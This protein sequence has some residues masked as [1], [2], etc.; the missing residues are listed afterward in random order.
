[1]QERKYVDSLIG[2]EYKQWVQGDKILISTPTGSGKTTFVISKLLKYAVEQRKH[3]AY[4]CNRRVLYEQIVV[5]SN[6]DIERFFTNDVEISET[7]AQYFHIYTYQSSELKENYPDISIVDADTGKRTRYTA[8]DI[9]YYIFDEAHYFVSDALI[10]SNTNFWYEK[11]F[12]FGISVF[13]TATPKPLMTLLEGWNLLS[14][15]SNRL[16]HRR[17]KSREQLEEWAIVAVPE[18][19]SDFIS[20]CNKCG[21]K[22]KT[23]S[24]KELIAAVMRQHSNFLEDWF[25]ALDETYHSSAAGLKIY[26]HE[27]DYSYVDP[28]YFTD[29][30]ELIPEIRKDRENNDKWLIF[31]DDE[32]EG[33]KFAAKIETQEGMSSVFLSAQEIRQGGAARE[34]YNYIIEKKSFPQKVMVATSV[35][36]CGIDIKSTDEAP[37]NNIVIVCDEE[38]SFLQMLGRRRVNSGERIRLFMKSFNTRKISNRNNQYQQYLSFLIKFSLKNDF[39]VIKR[40]KSTAY[41]DGNTYGSTLSADELN[42]LADDLIKRNL[43]A[44]VTR[45]QEKITADCNGHVKMRKKTDQMN[46]DD[47]LHEYEFSR[48]AFLHSMY[49]LF[50]YHYAM[51]HYRYES[52]NFTQLCTYVHKIL[53]Q[54]MNLSQWEIKKALYISESARSFFPFLSEKNPGITEIDYR[55]NTLRDREFYLKYQLDWIGKRYDIGCWLGYDEKFSNLRRFLDSLVESNQWLR[56]DE[57]WHEQSNFA[58]DCM[59][60]L[61]ELPEVPGVLLK[62]QSRYASNPQ[63]YPGKNKLETCFRTLSLPYRI[64]SVQRRYDGKRKSCWKLSKI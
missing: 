61:L 25:R 60:L 11:K 4:Y 28:V 37:V 38:A 33:S 23:P 26:T 43:A 10:N 52:E 12:Q 14:V 62:D 17:L 34:T 44:L 6:E 54:T 42:Q 45:S 39:E 16:L 19:L 30:D 64:V 53:T 7:A 35:I 18:V 3:I 40:G 15:E 36:D 47:H 13:L 20:E 58:R 32:E 31:V 24:S 22:V 50:D 59:E 9:L 48:T 2:D 57:I 55:S 63:L 1:M 41:R 49:R 27:P 46:Y 8:D 5:R 51:S 56:E 29:L 21:I